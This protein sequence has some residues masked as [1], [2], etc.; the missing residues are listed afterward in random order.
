MHVMRKEAPKSLLWLPI[1]A[2]CSIENCSRTID[3][4]DRNIDEDLR[5]QLFL[6]AEVTVKSWARNADSGANI[7]QPSLMKPSV[8][9]DRSS[10]GENLCF[11]TPSRFGS[12]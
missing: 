8:G 5:Q 7:L 3:K 1:I 6:A 4:S 12:T 11:S 9:Q 2:L 10:S